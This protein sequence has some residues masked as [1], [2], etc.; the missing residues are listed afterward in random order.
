[1]A[2]PAVIVCTAACSVFMGGPSV[3]TDVASVNTDMRT[4][5]T[6]GARV[7]TLERPV[8]A[9]IVREFGDVDPWTPREPL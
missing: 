6:A 7:N 5:H 8:D 1:M 4:M 9:A 2:L 3:F